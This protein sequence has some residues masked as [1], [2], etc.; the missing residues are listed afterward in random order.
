MSRFL[1]YLTILT[2]L[3]AFATLA[4]SRAHAEKSLAEIRAA[5]EAGVRHLIA[6]Q[7]PDGSIHLYAPS[8]GI[9]F[10]AYYGV[11]EITLQGNDGEDTVIVYGTSGSEA[12][13]M[14]SPRLESLPVSQKS[15]QKLTTG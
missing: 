1:R 13:A 15:Y 2:L 6:L 4:S 11:N 12:F 9:E 10:E 7:Q 5:I 3:G 14:A 8:S